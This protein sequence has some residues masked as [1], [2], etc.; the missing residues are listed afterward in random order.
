MLLA[1]TKPDPARH[2]ETV[3]ARHHDDLAGADG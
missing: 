3:R 1:V 2:L